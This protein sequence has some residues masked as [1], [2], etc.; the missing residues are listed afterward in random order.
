MI[1]NAGIDCKITAV[2]TR[3]EFASQLVGRDWDL[4]LFDYSLPAFDGLAA[5]A[6]AW[7]T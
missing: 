7:K 2:E 4:I 3:E 1:Q 6:M 5:M